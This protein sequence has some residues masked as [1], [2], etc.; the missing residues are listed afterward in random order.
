[1]P[2][3]L[4]E[5]GGWVSWPP[6]SQGCCPTVAVPVGMELTLVQALHRGGS[7]TSFVTRVVVVV[8]KTLPHSGHVLRMQ[9]SI[10]DTIVS[11]FEMER[12]YHPIRRVVWDR[13]L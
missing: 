7:T 13:L 9:H 10:Q 1:M 4:V 6:C 11:M 2:L 5:V 3:C 8:F 12:G